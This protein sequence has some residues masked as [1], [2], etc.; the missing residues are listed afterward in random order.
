[1]M[2]RRTYPRHSAR[3][4]LWAALVASLVGMPAMV[5]LLA[6]FTPAAPEVSDGSAHRCEV[7]QVR[8][9]MGTVPAA[10]Q[11]NRSI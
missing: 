10:A 9:E 3:I 7:E 5:I 2:T 11:P 1:M 4:P 8:F 6:V